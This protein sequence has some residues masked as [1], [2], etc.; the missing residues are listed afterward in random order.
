M[1]WI[2][3]QRKYILALTLGII[4]N[5][6]IGI[7]IY[8]EILALGNA[9]TLMTTTQIVGVISRG[10]IRTFDLAKYILSLHEQYQKQLYMM[11]L[12]VDLINYTTIDGYYDGQYIVGYSLIKQNKVVQ[13]NYIRYGTN[14]VSNV[15]IRDYLANY[16][17]IIDYYKTDTYFNFHNPEHDFVMNKSIGLLCEKTDFLN[18][19]NLC[20]LMDNQKFFYASVPSVMINASDIRLDVTYQNYTISFYNDTDMKISDNDQF[21]RFDTNI[22]YKLNNQTAIIKALYSD[23]YNLLK[24]NVS[25]YAIIMSVIMVILVL[26]QLLCCSFTICMQVSI[27]KKRESELL[28]QNLKTSTE[29]LHYVNHEMRNPLNVVFGN[30]DMSKEELSKLSESIGK[31]NRRSKKK[32]KNIVFIDIEGIISNLTTAYSQCKMMKHIVDDILDVEKIKAGEMALEYK[33]IVLKTLIINIQKITSIKSQE[34][35]H[36]EFIIDNKLP[37]N[38]T[39]V[40]DSYRL[41]QILMNFIS[42]AWKFTLEGTITLKITRDGNDLKFEVIDTGMGVP[43]TKKS[44]LFKPFKQAEIEHGTRYGGSGLGL[45]LCSLIVKTLGGKCGYI[46]MKNGDATGS[47]F[48]FSIQL[49]MASSKSTESV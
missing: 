25:D 13:V 22:T 7:V 29:M 47:T 40:S 2:L 32:L 35:P 10:S 26:L 44:G 28:G 39:F 14:N 6:I 43:E 49:E 9:S 1:Y 33:T 36:I 11:D 18:D 19:I 48:W 45:Y 38:F 42:N 21:R 41:D 15:E 16:T 8:Y 17:F 24:A 20:L 12:N 23:N 37:E 27:H 31:L 4:V 34:K 30:I 5:V 46:D 3:L